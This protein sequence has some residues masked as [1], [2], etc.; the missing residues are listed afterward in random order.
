MT[1]YFDIY[2]KRSY[3]NTIKILL[4]FNSEMINFILKLEIPF[5]TILTLLKI[6]SENGIK[7]LKI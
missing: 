7:V 5:Q 2:R 4:K 6:I 3:F 1:I